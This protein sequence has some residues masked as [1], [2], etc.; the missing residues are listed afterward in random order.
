MLGCNADEALRQVPQKM[1][2]SKILDNTQADKENW[3]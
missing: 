1:G 3:Q 2:A